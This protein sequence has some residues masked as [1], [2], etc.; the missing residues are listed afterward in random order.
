[1]IIGGLLLFIA[2]SIVAA[3]ADTML[4][5]MLGRGL[6]GL[7]AIA[8]T[9]MAMVTD[10]TSED[11]R[12]VA[13][14]SIGASI[15]LSFILA[16]IIGPVVASTMGLSGIFWLTALLG[17][18]GILI[19]LL[20]VPNSIQVQRNREALADINQVG[21]LLREPNLMRL[22]FSIFVLHLALRATFVVIPDILATELGLGADSLWWVYL[23]LLGGGFLLMVPMMVIG[24]KRQQQKFSVCVAVALLAVSSLVLG[25]QR[26][27][28]LT[29]LML[30]AF[31]AAFNLLEASLPS[32]LSKACPAGSRG[33][34]MGLYSTSQFLGAFAGGVLGGWSLQYFG[35]DGLFLVV[36]VISLV[37]LLVALRLE[38]PRPLQTVVL[39]I[40]DR[41]IED[42]ATI[43]SSTKGVEDILMVE[44][45]P[46]V[47]IKVDK[48]VV[49]MASLQPYLN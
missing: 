30:L 17:M 27:L 42:F 36:G 39:Q 16:M 19:F 37:W 33:T 10:L 21:V 44:G 11:K 7:G 25:W 31:F 3:M 34:A 35:V 41:D 13:M 23:V 28:I 5:L 18:L 14:A 40:G 22:N 12:T 43:I 6:Q 45:E 49:D 38:A 1:V 47:Y 20:F 9:L 26:S 4:S 46:L 2:G 48:R 32:W 8:S 15:G 29:P 24:E